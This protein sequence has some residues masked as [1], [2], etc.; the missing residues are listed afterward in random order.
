MKTKILF[1]TLL[2]KMKMIF[3]FKIIKKN[4]KLIILKLNNLIKKI[5]TINKYL[6]WLKLL[7][8]YQ[9]ILMKGKRFNKMG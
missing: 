8:D 2:D 9:M 1:L 7:I 4:L 3:R 5:K 6:T